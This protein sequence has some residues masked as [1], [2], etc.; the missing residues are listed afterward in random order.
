MTVASL[1]SRVGTWG[2]VLSTLTIPAGQA[3]G[4]GLAP[5]HGQPTPDPEALLERQLDSMTSWPGGLGSLPAVPSGESLPPGPDWVATGRRLFHDTRLSGDGRLSCASCHLPDHGLAEP[6][7]TAR[8]F[9]G[10][11]QRFQA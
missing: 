9:E 8:G 1:A 3:L 2:L 10:R 7:A 6:L 5:G 4:R 11:V